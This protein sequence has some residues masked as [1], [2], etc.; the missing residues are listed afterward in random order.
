MQPPDRLD[1]V[2]ED[3]GACT[4][5]G[6]QSVLLDVEK[7]RRQHLDR[8]VGQLRLER[9]DRRRVVS[10]AAIGNVV[11]IDGGD[12]DV[13]QLHLRRHVRE[14][15]RLE[16]VRR[17]VGLAAVHVAVAA[18]TRAR[19]PEDLERRRSTSPAL[20]DVRT[21]SLL[22]DRVQALAVDELLDVVVARAR[23]RRADLHPLRPARP[24]SDG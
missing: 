19:V 18:R 14:A 11:A 6:L 22:A 13:L 2:V 15:Q 9:A 5:D 3:V 10:G 4:D 7:V 8:R 16:R 20:A 23:A 1:V 21:A 17:A 24:L 12:D